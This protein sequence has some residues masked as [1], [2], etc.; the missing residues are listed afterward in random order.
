M[1]DETL[2]KIIILIPFALFAFFW[3]RDLN[4][5]AQLKSRGYRRRYFSRHNY[6]EEPDPAQKDTLRAYWE[7]HGYKW[8]DKSKRWYLPKQKDHSEELIEIERRTQ[9]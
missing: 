2:G 6:V 4:Q 9:P 8:S 5:Q 1:N 7:R 3:L